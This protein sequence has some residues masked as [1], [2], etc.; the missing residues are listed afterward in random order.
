LGLFLSKAIVE[1]HGGQLWAH[2]EV[3]KGTTFFV[4]IP[5]EQT[6]SGVENQIIKPQPNLVF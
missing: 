1:T 5:L 3:G 6:R 2:S 4:A